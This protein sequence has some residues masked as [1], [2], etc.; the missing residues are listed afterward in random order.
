MSRI[1]SVL[2]AA[3]LA[4]GVVPCARAPIATTSSRGRLDRLWVRCTR[5]YSARGEAAKMRRVQPMSNIV[6]PLHNISIGECNSHDY[7]CRVPD[8][9]LAHAPR[10]QIFLAFAAVY[11]I[12]GSTYLAI[13]FAIEPLPPILMVGSRFFVAGIAMYIWLRARG[14]APPKAIHWRSAVIL[15]TLMP[16]L[17]T[18]VVV[19]AERE[20]PSGI[21]A[22]LV[23]IEPLW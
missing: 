8:R 6:Q 4:S 7:F 11:I 17:G 18:G 3:S 5:A 15:G 16:V 2:S 23:A 21:A 20:V 9:P 13:R 14:A 10:S 19:W 12:W 22:L 1:A